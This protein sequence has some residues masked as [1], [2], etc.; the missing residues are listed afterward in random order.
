ME[1]DGKEDK[2]APPTKNSAVKRSSESPSTQSADQS[3]DQ[4]QASPKPHIVK[5]TK[6]D[7]S[8]SQTLSIAEAIAPAKDLIQQQSKTIKPGLNMQQITQLLENYKPQSSAKECIQSLH[9][10]TV[11]L[12]NIVT[13]LQ[14]IHQKIT[15]RSTKIRITKLIDKINKEAKTEAQKSALQTHQ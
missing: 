11:N 3:T 2:D 13:Q 14:T 15:D 6:S 9:P 5:K 1:C 8:N 7:D 4:V 12:Q 10:Q